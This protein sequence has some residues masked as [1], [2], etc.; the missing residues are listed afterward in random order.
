[1]NQ[2]QGSVIEV[3]RKFASNKIF[4]TRKLSFCTKRSHDTHATSSPPD[5][6]DVSIGR[7]VSFNAC[8]STSCRLWIR[9]S[10]SSNRSMRG[11]WFDRSR[12]DRRA[13]NFFWTRASHL[14][15][16]S[17]SNHFA[18]ASSVHP[19]NFLSNFKKSSSRV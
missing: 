14:E 11:S 19:S 6:K 2:S 9:R 12:S 4:L 17:M 3:D 5:Q 10:S 13:R 16:S 18:T 8:A 1:M 15:P 7:V